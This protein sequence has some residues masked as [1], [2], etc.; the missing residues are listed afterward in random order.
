MKQAASLDLQL[1]MLHSGI[2]VTTSPTDYQPIKK[3]FM[4][5]FDGQ[6]WVSAGKVTGR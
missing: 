5:Q 3:L 2:K 4:I 1:G 6:D